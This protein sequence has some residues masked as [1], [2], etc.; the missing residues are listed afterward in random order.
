V[1]KTSP[2][3]TG[4]MFCDRVGLVGS[5]C[6]RLSLSLVFKGQGKIFPKSLRRSKLHGRGARRG[7]S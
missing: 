7:Q 4:F 6:F 2:Y 1:G 3:P 5:V